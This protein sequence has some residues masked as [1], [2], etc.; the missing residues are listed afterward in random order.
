MALFPHQ[1]LECAEGT[2]HR[3][4]QPISQMRMSRHREAGTCVWGDTVHSQAS[5]EV[6]PAAVT[7]SCSISPFTPQEENVLGEIM[8]GLMFRQEPY[9]WGLQTSGAET[10]NDKVLPCHPLHLLS[11]L[12]PQSTAARHVPDVEKIT[13]SLKR[14]DQ[15]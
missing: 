11:P 8:Q 6:S 2:G 12:C 3:G 9:S 14:N 15:I 1:P 7:P 10:I 5:Q 13:C 4:Y